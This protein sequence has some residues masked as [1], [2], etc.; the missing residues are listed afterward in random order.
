MSYSLINNS[1][2]NIVL[3]ESHGYDKGGAIVAPGLHDAPTHGSRG[4]VD[5][6]RHRPHNVIG[7]TASVKLLD[8]IHKM[9]TRFQPYD[10]S[11]R[12]IVAMQHMKAGYFF[13]APKLNNDW[14]NASKYSS[15]KCL[16]EKRRE[17][18]FGVGSILLTSGFLF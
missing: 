16:H 8:F 7:R 18:G 10:R 5:S 13:E 14:K 6:G 3:E 15:L 4:V 11:T 9:K 1:P 2:C 17:D 12:G